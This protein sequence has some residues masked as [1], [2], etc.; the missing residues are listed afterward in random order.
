MRNSSAPTQ[1]TAGLWR[2]SNPGIVGGGEG[3]PSDVEGRLLDGV[4][5]ESRFGLY[6]DDYRKMRIRYPQKKI[7]EECRT[8]EIGI[9]AIAMARSRSTIE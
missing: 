5:I 8:C 7:Y 4:A 1:A 2:G 6:T 3:A 9:R